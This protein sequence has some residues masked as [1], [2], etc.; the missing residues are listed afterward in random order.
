MSQGVRPCVLIVDE[1][2]ERHALEELAARAQAGDLDAYGDL[3]TRTHRMTHGVALS[4]LRDPSLA[5]DAVQEAYLRAFRRLAD[6]EAPG[7]FLGWLR[8]T[9]VTVALNLR[10]ARRVTLLS[11]E[12]IADVPVLDET[13]ASWSER[14]R[15]R[16]AGALLALTPVERRLCDRRYHGG[17]TP[18]RLAHEAGVSETVMRKRLQ[19]VRDKLRERIEM[20]EQRDVRVE[21][22]R[23]DLPLRIV[24]LLARPRLNDLPENPV[25]RVLADLHGLRTDCVEIVL[26]EVI[27]LAAAREAVGAD[28]VYVEQSELHRVGDQHILRYDLTLPLFLH[29][30]YEGEPL[31]VWSAGKTYRRC[32]SDAVHLEAFHQLEVFHLDERSRLDPWQLTARVIEAVHHVLPGRALKMVPTTYAMCTQAWQLEVESHDRWIEVL[33]WGVFTDRIVRHLGGD[34]DRHRAAGIGCGLERLAMVRYEID[35][36]RRIESARVA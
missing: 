12:D 36:I 16:L 10:R 28:A 21:N 7:A 8:R 22:L 34:P 3:V 11:L 1:Q 24:E 33:A 29:L 27:D 25:G 26:P 15:Q 18:A 32:E 31:R 6:L 9:V 13:E 5:E 17:W 14:Q 2:M 35:D 4:V 20:A 19:R 23:A 30:R